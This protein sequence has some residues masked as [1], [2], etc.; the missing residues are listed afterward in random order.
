MTVINELGLY[1]VIL[2]SDKPEARRFKKWITSEVLPSI[3]RTG[4]TAGFL[5]S[6]GVT[7]RTGIELTKGISP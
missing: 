2:R 4:V 1:S 6:S 3:R 7:T 5:A